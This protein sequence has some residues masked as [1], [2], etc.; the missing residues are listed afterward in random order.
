MSDIQDKIKALKRPMPQ[1][2][3]YLIEAE[4][5]DIETLILTEARRI[6]MEAIGEPASLDG[7]AYGIHEA[8]NDLKEEQT[9]RLLELTKGA[10]N[11]ETKKTK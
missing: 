9:T 8:Q 1:E 6:G 3:Y 2:A 11:E 10:T 7:D 5:A 4:L